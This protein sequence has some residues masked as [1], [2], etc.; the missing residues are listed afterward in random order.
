MTGAATLTPVTAE[1]EGRTSA[2]LVVVVGRPGSGKTTLARSL[3]AHRRAAV[4]RIDAIE[5]ALLRSGEVTEPLGPVAYGV[6]AE[7]AAGCLAVGTPV[8]VDAVCPV[9]EARTGWR[10][11]ADAAGV[12]L[13]VVEVVLADAAEHRLRVERRLP[14]LEGQVVPT[15]AQVQAAPYAP[16]D[17]DRDGPRLIVDGASA[18]SALRAALRHVGPAGPC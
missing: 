2:V 1:V 7:V 8:V 12:P 4:V 17:E 16:W 3:A 9:P 14:D 18:V 15:W 11:L 6:A 10:A 5:A 13:R